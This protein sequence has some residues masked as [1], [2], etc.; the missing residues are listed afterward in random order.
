MELVTTYT[1]LVYPR[2]IMVAF[3]FIN[4]WSM[5]R[6]CKSYGLRYELRLLT[7]ASSYV[8]LVFGSRTLSN[9]I[10]MSLCSV[11]LYIVAEC[12]VHSNT[13]I[14][15]SEFL[16]EKYAS[17]TSTV[18]KVK[19]YKLESSLP[20][21]SFNRCWLISTICVTG[22]FN[23]PTFLFFGVPMVFFWLMRGMGT[24]STTFMD[25]NLRILSIVLTA[26]PALLLFILVDSLY[27]G[28]LSLAEI[29]HL[30]VGI[31][32]F[33]VTPLNFIRYNINPENTAQHGVHPKYLH[34]AVNIPLL[35]NILGI[36]SIC[37]FGLM[38]Y[39]FCHAEYKDLPRAQS[40]V[41]LMTSSIFVPVLLLSLINHQEPRFLLPLTLP[42]IFLHAP[43]LEH[44]F[45]TKNPFSSQHPLCELIYK[46]L[47]S[48]NA[49]A[50]FLLKYWF[51]INIVMTLF[52]G[53]IHQGGTV[54]LANHLSTR[55]QTTQHTNVHMHL[56]TSHIYN[57]PVSL[58]F[59]PSTKTTLVNP[60][61][62]QKYR[63]NKRLFLY[64]YGSMDMD[65]LYKKLKLILDVSE[66]KAAGAQQ[67]RYGDYE[68]LYY[69]HKSEISLHNRTYF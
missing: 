41:T 59:L 65:Q 16:Q 27:Y 44:G 50:G 69:P 60:E 53:F 39:R 22:C 63:R 24:R 43:K 32:N 58:F 14:F 56:V 30:Q 31:N 49:S 34:L 25:F 8:M 54:Q 66:M 15:Q 11:L 47:L 37:S 10:E 29:Q 26:I 52:F 28:Y 55:L 45:S 13:V 42:I 38:I 4:D 19:L 21:H 51:V 40:V 12:M 17:A 67:Q 62:G 5:Y 9:T 36:V 33:V 61:T 3:S 35:Y 2:L 1:L 64:E 57:I 18:E 48:A 23:R 68:N 7:L 46:H 20:R 6:I